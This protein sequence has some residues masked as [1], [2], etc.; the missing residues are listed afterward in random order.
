VAQPLR[1]GE[2]PASAQS[3][4]APLELD[5][6]KAIGILYRNYRGETAE[7]KIVP[8]RLWFGA[9]EWHPEEQWLLDA[10]DLDK[11]APRSFALRDIQ[12]YLS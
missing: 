3:T 11:Q 2:L 5:Q 6:R 7:R 8:Q 10:I 1:A 9:T 4:D 12:S